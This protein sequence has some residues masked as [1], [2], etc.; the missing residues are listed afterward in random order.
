MSQSVLEIK[1]IEFSYG[2]WRS[3]SFDLIISEGKHFIL[4]GGSG[5]GKSSL[6]RAI[7]GFAKFKDGEIFCFGKKINEDNIYE[8]RK[9][10]SWLPQNLDIMKAPVQDKSTLGFIKNILEISEAKFHQEKI[11]KYFLELNLKLDL[12]KSDFSSL[13]LGERQRVG[14]VVCALKE[15]KLWLLDEPTSSLDAKNTELV[16]KFI[17]KYISTALIISHSNLLGLENE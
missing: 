3:E 17:K 2:S 16:I 8:I 13:S 1:N 5:S 12:L 15:K 10:I 6:L 11:E 9:Q 4:K 7:L 14:L